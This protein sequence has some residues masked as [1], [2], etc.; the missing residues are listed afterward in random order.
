MSAVDTLL[1]QDRPGPLSSFYISLKFKISCG[2]FLLCADPANERIPAAQTEALFTRPTLS[3]CINRTQETLSRQPVTHKHLPQV[4][5]TSAACMCVFLCVRC[6]TEQRIAPLPPLS[7]LLS[8]WNNR[9]MRPLL[10]PT[11]QLTRKH[12]PTCSAGAADGHMGSLL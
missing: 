6:Q 12:S 9:G 2:F 8:H 10:S 7:I 3:R 5:E 11:V 1:G 4:I